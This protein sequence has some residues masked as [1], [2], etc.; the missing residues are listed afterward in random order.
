MT[1]STPSCWPPR[2]K[3]PLPAVMPDTQQKGRGSLFDAVGE[4]TL[5]RFKRQVQRHG[6]LAGLAGSLRFEHLP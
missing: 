2:V 6:K 3:L 1:A 5:Q 4:Y